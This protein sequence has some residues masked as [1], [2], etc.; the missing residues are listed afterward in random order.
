MEFDVE[1][2]KNP[3]EETLSAMEEMKAKFT[4]IKKG[5]A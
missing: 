4:K 2:Y 3:K 5:L 1:E